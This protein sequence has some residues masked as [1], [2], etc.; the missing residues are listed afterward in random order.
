M[1]RKNARIDAHILGLLF[2]NPEAPAKSWE[3]KR[4]VIAKHR[5][6]AAAARQQAR[7]DAE[8]REAVEYHDAEAERLEDELEAAGH[9]RP[10]GAR[11]RKNPVADRAV[12]IQQDAGEDEEHDLFGQAHA[13]FK[14]AGIYLHSNYD[15]FL[16]FLDENESVR[17]AAALALYDTDEPPLVEFSVVVAPDQKRKGLAKRLVEEVIKHTKRDASEFDWGDD[18]EVEAYVVNEEAMIPLLT[19][20]GFEQSDA[21]PKRWRRRVFA[22]ANP[23]AVVDDWVTIE[24]SAYALD[25]DAATVDD[26]I[27]IEECACSSCSVRMNPRAAKRRPEGAYGDIESIAPVIENALKQHGLTMS[28]IAEVKFT[29]GGKSRAGSCSYS[30]SLR[31]CKIM[32]NG[33]AWPAF[34]EEQ[35]LNTILHEAAH[36]IQFLTTG[37][38]D[39]GPV[40]TRIAQS[41]GCSGDR[42]MSVEASQAMVD[43][44]AEAKGLPK[45]QVL[46]REAA[47]EARGDFAVGD[48]VS[49]EHKRERWYGKITGKDAAHARVMV[50]QPAN[51][52]GVTGKIPYPL[53]QKEAPPRFADKV[54]GV[55]KPAAGES[56]TAWLERT[57]R[58]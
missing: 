52:V 40:W 18:V 41:I 37:R 56:L 16:V 30:P 13:L 21:D 15:R 22:R 10:R 51:R 55:D 48:Y 6:H 5:M 57:G 4:A 45:R 25:E 3:A 53:L 8:A 24:D 36:A 12:F 44:Y 26:W 54:A 7:Y 19:R 43:A 46:T 58:R 38:S 33:L 14:E 17:A 27:T 49:F 9:L 35:R 42:C 28:G 34:T 50:Q 39:H 2:P 11:Y 20:L 32:F 29:R 23:R 1:A 47:M 31:Q